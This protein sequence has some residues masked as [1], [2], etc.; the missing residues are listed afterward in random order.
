MTCCRDKKFCA[1][2]WG[3]LLVAMALG[4]VGLA[5]LFVISGCAAGKAYERG[6]DGKM[7]ERLVFGVDAGKLAEGAT[8]TFLSLTDPGTLAALGGV[9]VPFGILATI[10]GR[11]RGERKG[12]DEAKAE[13]ETNRKLADAAYDEGAARKATT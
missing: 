13:A 2:R 8:A 9:A 5:M 10:F 6:P 12:W 1:C 3:G 7:Q 11:W 4:A